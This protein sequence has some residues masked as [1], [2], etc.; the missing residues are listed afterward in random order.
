MFNVDTKVYEQNM[1]ESVI[2]SDNYQA[3]VQCAKDMMKKKAKADILFMK[4]Y[5]IQYTNERVEGFLDKIEGHDEY[6]IVEELT[7][8]S[9]FEFSMAEL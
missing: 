3:G 1:V 6:K 4:H 5:N 7:T 2:W 9:V 8:T